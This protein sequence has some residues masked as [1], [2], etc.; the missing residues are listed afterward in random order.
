RLKD[1]P[2]KQIYPG[3][4]Q[5]YRF[6]GANGKFAGDEVALRS[7]RRNAEALLRPVVTRGSPV[8]G[9]V[10]EGD[11]AAA[12]ARESISKLPASV[13]RL[14]GDG[15]DYPVRISAAVTDLREQALA[16]VR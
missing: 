6:T 8:P 11:A 12:H 2:D 5:V 9:S 7:E 1:S 16:R 15:P 3:A 14:D 4:K 13:Q 10:L